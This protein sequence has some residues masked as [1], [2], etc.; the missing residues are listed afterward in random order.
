MAMLGQFISVPQNFKISMK[1]LAQ[2]DEI[3]E[4]TLRPDIWWHEAYHCKKWPHSDNVRSF[5]SR[6]A[7]GA[8]AVW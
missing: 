6:P 2:E 1:G 4:I 5:W 3:D 8:V 7:A